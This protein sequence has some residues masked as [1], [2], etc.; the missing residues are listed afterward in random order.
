MPGTIVTFYSWKGGVGRSMA[1][2][3]IAVQLAQ[4]GNSV[5]MV[6][7]DLEAPGLDRYFHSKD[8]LEAGV[9]VR[10]A[11]DTSGLSGLLHDAS[12][13]EGK[14]NWRSRVKAISVPKLG[15]PSYGNVAPTPNLLHLLPSGE[16][17]PGFV[18]RLQ[19]FSWN[20]FY[21]NS[22]GAY[23]LETL[24]TEWASSY[25]FVLIDSR[26]GLTD[27]GGVCTIHMPDWLVLVFTSNEQ[28]LEGGLR[29]VE[30]IQKARKDFAFDRM[31][32]NVV[33]L[34]SRW[35]G[36]SEVDLAARWLD[37]A[38]V[39]TE[40]YF[41][42]WLPYTLKPRL[43]YD[44]IRV[45]HIARFSFGEPL[46]VVSHSITDEG[47]PGLAYSRIARLFETKFSEAGIIIDPTFRPAQSKLGSAIPVFLKDQ[48]D[49]AQLI[50]SGDSEFAAEL[51]FQEQ[52]L[53]AETTEFVE[54]LLNLGRLLRASTNFVRSHLVL[55]R[56]VNISE[57]IF[58][59]NDPKVASALSELAGLLRE[60]NR[61]NEAEPLL[62]RALEINQAHYGPNDPHVAIDLVN[63]AGLL[64]VK[65][66]LR[67]AEA[68]FVRAIQIDESHYGPDHPEVATDL[69]NYAALLERTNRHK[70]A[71]ALYRRALAI[72]ERAFGPE[73]LEVS[74]VLNN[75]A[76][77]LRTTD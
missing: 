66:E 65:N 71:E 37:R 73:H 1:L 5:L 61:A 67:E 72:S 68:L 7:W 41:S 54:Y 18:D 12:N 16:G 45:P 76:G 33:P 11:P 4:R 15:T 29:M 10:E 50:I 28:S 31:P 36:D 77:L 26:T 75:L 49:L 47:L 6:D 60:T 51:R 38:A 39:A 74:A 46:P 14:T 3:N 23:F 34:L 32:L 40:E 21:A 9:T 55:R 25:D 52:K 24:R 58:S 27:A 69:N 53:G 64:K 70:E 48:P 19:N 2:A 42:S 62:R 22:E 56:A 63:L 44:K 59:L 30:G 20:A 43:Y 8:A 35:D 13:F 17:Q 57:K